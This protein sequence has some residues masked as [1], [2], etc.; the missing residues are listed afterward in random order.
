MARKKFKTLTEQMYYILLSLTEPCCG[1]DIMNKV[2]YLSNQRIKIGPGTLYTLLGNFQES[3]F[4]KE[5]PALG[6]KRSY[7][8]TDFGKKALKSE[9]ERLLFLVNDGEKYIE[10]L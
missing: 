6:R 10:K 7:T 4:I 3:G 2:L 9:Y 5:I 1:I 8:I